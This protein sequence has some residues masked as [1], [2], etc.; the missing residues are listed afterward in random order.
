MADVK[1]PEPHV[2][3]VPAVDIRKP[4]EPA[5]GE[6]PVL[7]PHELFA[8]IATDYQKLWAKATDDGNLEAFLGEGLGN[9]RP[10]PEQPPHDKDR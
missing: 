7:L 3:E 8:Q 6:C 1:I 2:L 4:E 10:P 9:W 5:T